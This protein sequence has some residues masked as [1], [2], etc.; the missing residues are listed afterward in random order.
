MIA[1]DSR[2][3]GSIWRLASASIS[4][5]V[6]RVPAGRRDFH[7]PVRLEV[8]RVRLHVIEGGE[9]GQ[10]PTVRSSICRA[11]HEVVRFRRGNHRADQFVELR[12]VRDERLAPQTKATRLPQDGQAK[13]FDV[14]HQRQLP[15]I[16]S[17]LAAWALA[18]LRVGVRIQNKRI[19][20]WQ[21]TEPFFL[22]WF[23]D[24]V[25][26]TFSNEP[27]AAAR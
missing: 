27:R 1:R 5:F 16:R 3:V 9:P 19:S 26:L 21:G 25:W 23:H 18:E 12:L 22:R 17:R 14:N 13:A 7:V 15:E 4:G 10:T 11:E 20:W 6:L 24:Q 2:R 8:R